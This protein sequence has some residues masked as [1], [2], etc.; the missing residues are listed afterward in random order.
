MEKV[1]ATL[2]TQASVET[3]KHFLSTLL[4]EKFLF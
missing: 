1:F 4:A 2:I 3:V